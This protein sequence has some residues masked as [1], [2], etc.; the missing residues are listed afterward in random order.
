VV[1]GEVAMISL[2]LGRKGFQINTDFVVV[3]NSRKDIAAFVI[4]F[5]VL[6]SGTV[7]SFRIPLSKISHLATPY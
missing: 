3:N 7:S 4:A 2:E 1:H 5:E 6:G